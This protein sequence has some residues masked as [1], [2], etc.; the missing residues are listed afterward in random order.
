[1]AA[2]SGGVTQADSCLE[3]WGGEGGCPE[4]ELLETVVYCLPIW[5]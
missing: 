1:M 2:G 3:P 5:V 4:R